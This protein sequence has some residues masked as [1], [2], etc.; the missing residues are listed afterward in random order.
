MEMGC[1]QTSAFLVLIY[2]KAVWKGNLKYKEVF[3][4][5]FKY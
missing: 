2:R 5:L 1:V 3:K 4:K